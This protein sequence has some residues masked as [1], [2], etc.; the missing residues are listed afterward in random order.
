MRGESLDK[1]KGK[2]VYHKTLWSMN[3]IIIY[4]MG[5][6]KKEIINPLSDHFTKPA[7]II[8]NHQSFLD[9][10]V[11]IMLHPKLILITNHWVYNSPVFG[12]VVSLAE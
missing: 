1:E 10:L 6:V 3:W 8:C 2:L 9:I 4:I 5:N 12:A 11:T 7:V